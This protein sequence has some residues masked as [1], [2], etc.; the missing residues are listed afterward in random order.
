MLRLATGPVTGSMTQLDSPRGDPPGS[1]ARG[2]SP[3]PGLPP[4]SSGDRIDSPRGGGGGGFDTRV[5]ETLR[6]ISEAHRSLGRTALCLSGGGALAMY[7]FGVIKV[8]LEEGLL[9]QVVSGTS[10]G[11]IVAAFISMFP[12][13]E[14]L[15]TIKPD[16]SN[17]H[18]VRWFPPVW[19]NL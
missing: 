17:R 6:L 8:L 10:G 11:S 12:E 16:L 2:P 5:P 14:L 1:I 18:D 9:P 15:K 4:K 7:H 3:P 13:E 19:K